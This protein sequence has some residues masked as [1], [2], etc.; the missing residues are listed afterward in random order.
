MDARAIDQI[1]PLSAEVAILPRV[2]GSGLF[3]R[4]QTQVLTICTLGSLSKI[5]KLD[6]LDDDDQKRYMHHYNFPGYSVG[7]A[8]SNRSPGRREIGHGALAERSLLPVLP[9]EEEFPYAIRLVSEVTMSNGSTS[10]GAVCGSTLALM[11]AG[12]P[13]KRPVAGI[14]TGLIVN[15]ENEE[16]FLVF[17]DIQ[18]IEDF[19]GDMDFK[20]AGT[21]EGITSIQMDLKVDGLSF[22]MIR[23]AFELTRTGRLQIIN[24]ILLPC[25]DK[26]RGELSEYA[27]KILQTTI[28][29]DKIREVIGAGGKVINKIIAETGT[30]IDI[31]SDTGRVFVAA[32]DIVA[33]RRAIA[34]I[35]GI[36]ND[37][38]VGAV[39]EG[40]VTRLMTFGA[41]IEF[42]PGKEGLVH[43]SKM[44]WGRVDKVED[45]VKEGD[46]VKVKVLELDSQGRI[47]LSMRDA[48]EKPDG[49]IEQA[50]REN[51]FSNDRGGSRGGDRPSNSGGDRPNFRGGDRD[52][53]GP[54]GPDRRPPSNERRGGFRD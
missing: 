22:D 21:T 29:I 36:A 5:Q 6:G 2:H 8:K 31:D 46:I 41:F 50:P 3:A 48:T 43:I 45:V 12:V 33:G 18:G 17:M 39:Y 28:A 24:D 38:E 23:Q 9:T 25:I 30:E 14:S 47:N 32:R 11:D 40:K 35:E 16:D 44:A 54:G 34:I 20:V 4:G 10:Q 42:L 27:P 15:E 1:R 52:H 19:F 7:E 26:P 53:R 37:P 13:I 51:S 49:F